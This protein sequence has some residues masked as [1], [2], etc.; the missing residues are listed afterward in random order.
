MKL[1]CNEKTIT[2]HIFPACTY[3]RAE[4]KSRAE[5][6][7]SRG[8][9]AALADF[10]GPRS[11]PGL[12]LGPRGLPLHQE[13]ADYGLRHGVE[14]IAR[15]ASFNAVLLLQ[16]GLKIVGR[17]VAERCFFHRLGREN[18]AGVFLNIFM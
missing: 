17:V 10:L 18:T 15:F 1:L 11:L 12:L 2:P 16:S 9:G 4:H 3:P 5:D 14:G 13:F 7:N 8:N 6:G